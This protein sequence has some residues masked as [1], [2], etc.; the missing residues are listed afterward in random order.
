MYLNMPV[1]LSLGVSTSTC[2]NIHGF[3]ISHA[4]YYDTMKFIFSI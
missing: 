4:S 3:N 1:I 2:T